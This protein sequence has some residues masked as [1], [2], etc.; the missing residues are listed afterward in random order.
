MCNVKPKENAPPTLIGQF[1]LGTCRIG[2]PFVHE[3][4]CFALVFIFIQ[5]RTMA[6]LLT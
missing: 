1:K 3:L 4:H 5:A 2:E 6:S